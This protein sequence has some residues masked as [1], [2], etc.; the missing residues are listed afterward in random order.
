[1][2]PSLAAL[3]LVLALALPV[4]AQGTSDVRTLAEQGDAEA[5]FVLGSMYRDG[6]GVEKDLEE[7]LR[8]WQRAAELGNVDAQ[9]ALG[10]IYSGG[11]GVT[12]DYVQSYMWFDITAAQT[13]IVWLTPI[14]RSNRDALV[15]RMTDAEVSKA[16]RMSADWIAKHRK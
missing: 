14:A 9:F 15:D 3:A 13:E 1:M 7:T 11:F 2:S 10:D 8:W 12:R 4:W 16:K 6:Q 5:Q